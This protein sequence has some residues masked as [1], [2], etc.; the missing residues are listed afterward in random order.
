MKTIIAPLSASRSCSAVAQAQRP[1]GS[2]RRLG[3]AAARAPRRRPRPW[4]RRPD[5]RLVRRRQAA[6]RGLQGH[7]ALAVAADPARRQ[8]HAAARR[9]HRRCRP[10]VGSSC[11]TPSPASLKEYITNPVVTVIVVETMPPVV[12]VIG[13]VNSAGPAAAQRPDVGAAGARAGRRLQGLREHEGHPQSCARVRS[14]M[15]TT[16]VQLQGR[17]RRGT[18]A[19]RWLLPG[20]TII[21]R[22]GGPR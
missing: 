4:P 5:Y 19:N 9:R 6:H 2:I 16:A 1:A 13:E 10:H 8:D 17:D 7:A 18:G 15:Q 21:V 14:G 20:D 3:T 12:Y 11:A 22:S